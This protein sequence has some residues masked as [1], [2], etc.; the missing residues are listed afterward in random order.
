M[1]DLDEAIKI[2]LQTAQHA[3]ALHLGNLLLLSNGRSAILRF[4]EVFPAK[5]LVLDTKLS[6]N[7]SANV[8]FFAQCGIK[9][10][11]VLAGINN[12]TIQQFAVAAHANNMSVALDLVACPS[13]EQGVFDA[14][15]LDIDSIVYR[16]PLLKDDAESLLERWANV[17]GN[18]QLPIFIGGTISFDALL[19]IKEM[20]PH[21][22]IVG[23]L[24]TNAAN[25]VE[26]AEK[27]RAM[28]DGAD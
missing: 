26:M 7:W 23:G 8:D 22:I 14:Q 18:T 4:R 3:D 25:P 13:P 28:I 5:D 24:I 15:A 16:N 6:D 1:A 2:A 20:A 19:P 9:Q 17:K 11:S 12:K 10:I 21:G 27:V